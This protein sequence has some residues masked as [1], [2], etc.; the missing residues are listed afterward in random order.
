MHIQRSQMNSTAV[1]PYFAAAEKVLAV[2]RA[3]EVR[4]KLKMSAQNLEGGTTAEEAFLIGQWTDARQSDDEY[5][6]GAE[7]KDPDSG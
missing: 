3:A 5:H 1:N 4:K 2:Q 6:A 7:G